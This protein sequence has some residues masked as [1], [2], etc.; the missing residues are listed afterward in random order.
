MFLESHFN[1]D[2]QLIFRWRQRAR[3][4]LG[5]G[6]GRIVLEVEIEDDPFAVL[7]DAVRPDCGGAERR[8]DPAV[9]TIGLIL[10]EHWPDK[11][12]KGLM[13][14]R[15]LWNG[16]PRT[17]RGLPDVYEPF[18]PASFL[19]ACTTDCTISFSSV[20]TCTSAR[21]LI[22]TQLLPHECAPSLCSS[23]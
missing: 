3:G 23:S 7:D 13:S 18:V 5:I 8:C 22:Y 20:G 4:E 21:R 16:R 10:C 12:G 1:C 6:A 15:S 11:V 2:G 9:S 14:D 17:E 19:R